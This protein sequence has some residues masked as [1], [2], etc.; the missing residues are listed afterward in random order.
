LAEVVGGAFFSAEQF[1][2]GY[3]RR[4]RRVPLESFLSRI[5]TGSRNLETDA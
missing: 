3:A 1:V 4:L 5:R 2:A